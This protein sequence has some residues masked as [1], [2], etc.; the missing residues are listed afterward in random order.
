MNL[1]TLM[2]R[3]EREEDGAVALE[4]LGDLTLYAEIAA[5]GEHHDETPGAYV[6]NASRRF[7]ALAG[8]EDWQQLMTAMERADAPASAA[9]QRM[10]RWALTEDRKALE[11]RALP[12]DMPAKSV[13]SCGGGGG[14]GCHG[15]ETA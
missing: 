7:A 5:M 15:H 1:G 9:L 8:D 4:A 13:C 2:N 3:L 12:A 14:G 11:Q 10:L 6:A